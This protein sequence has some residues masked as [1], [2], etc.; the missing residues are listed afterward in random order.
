MSPRD[1]ALTKI[2]RFLTRK[3]AE[4]GFRHSR[5]YQMDVPITLRPA[6]PNSHR[7]QV[8]RASSVAELQPL[9]EQREAWFG[10]SARQRLAEGDV[11]FVAK[12]DGKVVS[13]I[14]GT[15]TSV[16]VSEVEYTMP[17]DD[18]TVA[19]FDSYT[20]PEHRGKYAYSSVLH[21][22][23]NHCREAGFE[24]IVGFIA[25]DNVRSLRVH[26]RLGVNRIISTITM[27]R[28]LGVRKHFFK[29]MDCLIEDVL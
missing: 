19:L 23:I 25:P 28:F 9:I 24:R 15:L 21:A 17:L 18:P 2:A 8:H 6:E 4:L 14:F 22:A 26:Q 11:C 29:A 13:C 20:L 12:L 16:L 27:V 7:F 5:V 3:A 10:R 1:S